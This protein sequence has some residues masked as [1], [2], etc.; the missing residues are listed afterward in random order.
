VLF[1]LVSLYL[2]VVVVLDC[3]VVGVFPTLD[4]RN[5][6]S[7]L[8]GGVG[9][10]RCVILY[11]PKKLADWIDLLISSDKVSRRSEDQAED[12]VRVVQECIAPISCWHR[13]RDTGNGFQRGGVRE[14]C[15]LF[16]ALKNQ[17]RPC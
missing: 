12:A 11:D 3:F 7:S 5:W 6:S 17:I 16:L 10:M 8:G 9:M 2:G 14:W 1:L 15:V 13:C 4:S